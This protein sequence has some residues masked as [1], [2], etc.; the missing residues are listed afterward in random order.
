MRAQRPFILRPLAA[1]LA[2]SALS[3]TV[4]GPV[5][6]QTVSPYTFTASQRFMTDSNVYR[7]EDT[8]ANKQSDRISA[9][10]LGLKVDQPLGRQGLI[11]DLN[12]TRYK[13][14]QLDSLNY[15]GYNGLLKL[16]LATAGDVTG[17]IGI[18]QSQSLANQTVNQSE[19]LERNRV[20]SGRVQLGMT[21]LWSVEAG[22]ANRKVDESD[23]A[24]RA[25]E[26]KANS[27]NLGLRYRP[28]DLISFGIGYR[29]TKGD[30]LYGPVDA[31]GD[32]DAFDRD[33]IDFTARWTPSDIT[34]V[35][36]RLSHTNQ[37]HTVREPRDQTLL[38]SALSMTWQP[39][40]ILG[41]ELQWVRDTNEAVGVAGS[42]LETSSSGQAPITNAFQLAL[43]ANWS[44]QV[45]GIARAKVAKRSFDSALGQSASDNTTSFNVGLTY[46][47]VR[48]LF[49]EAGVGT[50]KRTSS[51]EALT[52][53][54]PYKVNTGFIGLGLRLN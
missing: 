51:N 22:A 2:L 8:S 16:N 47:P 20:I 11:V 27:A 25:A 23:E 54:N 33:D 14:N 49:V 30:Y 52:N 4:C 3:I 18:Q 9:T 50:E 53:S 43:T 35:N 29:K 37:S 15:T 42:T 28:S 41:F 19:N 6:A 7:R 46:L 36:A 1:A 12:A 24:F 34:T 31:N 44:A 38:T 26:L 21:S 32:P 10:S 45:Q 39:T 48:Y 13:Y 40:G 17:D 5:Q